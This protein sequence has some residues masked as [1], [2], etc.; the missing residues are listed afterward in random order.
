MAKFED[1][2]VLKDSASE[3]LD[4]ISGKMSGLSIKGEKIKSIFGNMAKGIAS[5]AGI[6]VASVGALAL[7][8]SRA[9]RDAEELKATMDLLTGSS[10]KSKKIL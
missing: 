8:C 7:S 10:E 9:A 6:S 2:L 4:K 3:K 1:E 5:A